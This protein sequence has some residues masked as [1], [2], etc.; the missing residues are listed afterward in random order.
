MSSAELDI[1]IKLKS[2]EPYNGI[3]RGKLHLELSG[4][5]CN[6]EFVNALGKIAMKRIPNYAY[7]KELIQIQK[8][9]PETGFHDSVPF[10]YDMIR[11]RIKNTP[12]AGVDPGI[13]Y[14]HERYWQNVLYL[15]AK[16]EKHEVEKSIEANINIENTTDDI[17]H[18]TTND[19]KI[20]VNNELQQI[21]NTEYPFLI[22][23]LKPQE[24]FKCSMKAVL[25]V[26]LNDPCWNSA[27][28]YWYD[29]TNDNKIDFFVEGN[30]CFDEYKLI[31]RAIEYYKLRTKLLK[32]EIN[33]QYL[34]EKTKKE[35]FEVKIINEDHTF[36]QI[37]N[38][39]LQHHKNIKIS[40]LKKPSLLV[41]EIILEIIVSPDNKNS[42]INYIMESF[43]NLLKK[44]DVFENKYNKLLNKKN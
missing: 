34:L 8:I 38:Y 21:Y 27:G 17:I 40:S 15:D 10:N 36:G 26:G 22:I 20:Y 24:A 41:R 3:K 43:D 5:D 9:N 18:I 32:D 30:L 42:M 31:S 19:M 6:L 29:Q 1:N 35:H 33:R 39:E 23:S 4:K 44:I 2:F 37:I 25:G 13:A 14:L 12:V 11:N 16:R 7:A 28:N